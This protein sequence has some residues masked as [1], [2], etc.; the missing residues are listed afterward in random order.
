MT[1]C[2][3]VGQ[4][5]RP[6]SAPE[7]LTGL[8]KTSE[9]PRHCRLAFPSARFYR[10]HLLTEYLSRALPIS[11]LNTAP[12][13]ILRQSRQRGS[14]QWALPLYLQRN[15]DPSSDLVAQEKM[16]RQACKWIIPVFPYWQIIQIQGE[17]LLWSETKHICGPDSVNGPWVWVLLSLYL[18][19]AFDISV[20]IGP[21]C[22]FPGGSVV[23]TLHSQCRAH[24][25]DPWLGNEDP[26]CCKVRSK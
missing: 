11:P 26:A 1:L 23:K 24:E 18:K 13:L 5:W 15:V 20:Y 21:P 19:M 25:F 22:D 10:L 2:L 12:H 4:S 6:I 17:K 8:P 9:T 14:N 7:P 3:D 16:D